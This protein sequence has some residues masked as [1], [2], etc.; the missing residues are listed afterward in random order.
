MS[1]KRSTP[2]RVA[3][4]QAAPVMFDTEATIDKLE[5][6]VAQAASEGAQLV[7]FGESFIAGFPLWTSV[8][9]P[10]DQ[11][12]FQVRMVESAIEVPG[13]QVRRLG[14]IARDHGVTLSVGVNEVSRVSVGTV[15][16]ANLVFS[17]DGELVNHRRKLVAT[18]CERLAWSHGDAHDLQPV[19]VDGA[20][21][22]VLLCGENTN[23]LARYALLAQGEE[24]HI[25]TYP[26]AW[27]FDRSDAREEYD[28]AES[29]R[30]RSAAHSFEGK[31]FNIVA[32]TALGDDAVELVSG[33][34]ES[35]V[36]LLGA[37]PTASMILGPTGQYL[38][39]P[40]VGEEGILYADLTLADRIVPKQ[41]HDIVGTYNR[42]DVFALS[43]DKTRHEPTGRITDGAP[44]L[45]VGE[46]GRSRG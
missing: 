22:G 16:N 11:H 41:A 8:L 32:S 28:L 40:L 7:A 25:A 29:I 45:P 27:P 6:L 3:A 1:I 44:G 26:P 38:A 37:K 23:T 14:A 36:K 24:V 33:G 39:G 5:G 21:V 43:V 19:D 13:P 10:V 12:D 15:W 20:Q 4:V 35:I 17:H 42:F 2:L 31:V 30:L 46:G 9:P 18:W 34:D